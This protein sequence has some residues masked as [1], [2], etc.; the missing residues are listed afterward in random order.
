[1]KLNLKS[2]MSRWSNLAGVI[3]LALLPFL[4]LATAI[5]IADYYAK[6]LF[7]SFEFSGYAIFVVLYLFGMAS[8][9]T[10]STIVLFSAHK[11]IR[12]NMNLRGGALCVFVYVHATAVV[13]AA[14]I[15]SSHILREIWLIKGRDTDDFLM[16][17]LMT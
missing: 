8:V 11:Y 10:S 1:M 12:L 13:T 2:Y 14:V 4:I 16:V 9:V 3:A 17:V 6:S 5:Y 15:F 7:I